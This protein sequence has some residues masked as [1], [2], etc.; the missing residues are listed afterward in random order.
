LLLLPNIT[1]RP[2]TTRERVRDRPRAVARAA[3]SRSA[4]FDAVSP[5]ADAFRL[6]GA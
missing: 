3:R 5:Q 2:V 1:S 6:D 4:V